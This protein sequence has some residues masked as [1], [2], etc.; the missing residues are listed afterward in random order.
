MRKVKGKKLVNEKRREQ[1]KVQRN[2][3]MNINK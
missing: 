1:N 2:E 3:N